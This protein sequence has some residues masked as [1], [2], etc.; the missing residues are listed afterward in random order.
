MNSDEV[1][2]HLVI[3]SFKTIMAEDIERAVDE[4]SGASLHEAIAD[5][6]APLGGKQTITATHGRVLVTTT[7]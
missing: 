3:E 1:T 2:Y 7:R 5:K 6:L 4:I